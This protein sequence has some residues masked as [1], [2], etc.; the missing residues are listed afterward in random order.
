LLRLI[1]QNIKKKE[2]QTVKS[3]QS[4]FDA[5]TC[6]YTTFILLSSYLDKEKRTRKPCMQECPLSQ[7]FIK[8]KNMAV[9][10]LS[11]AHAFTHVM[12]SVSYYFTEFIIL[13]KPLYIMVCK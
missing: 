13:L 1:D 11:K 3:E 12:R 10:G 9:G 2:K 7:Q 5:K 8:L 6:I 4:S